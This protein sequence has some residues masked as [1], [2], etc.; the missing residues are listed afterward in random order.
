MQEFIRIC[1]ITFICKAPL[2]DSAI[3]NTLQIGGQ[4]MKSFLARFRRLFFAGTLALIITLVVSIFTGG[5][6]YLDLWTYGLNLKSFENVFCLFL[7]VSPI[8]YI[9]LAIIST[10]YIRKHGQ[11]AAY[12]QT[13]PF[14][15]T[16]F[17]CVAS[18]F[19]SPF[20]CISGFF[21]AVFNKYPSIYPEDLKKK[22]KAISI[23]RFIWMILI[24][25]FCV[26]GL[27]RINDFAALIQTFTK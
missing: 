27:I 25:A 3:H 12:Q 16:F 13:K 17:Q 23:G 26:Y 21:T 2:V 7:A 19:A 10:A 8:V 4:V 20:K 1:R 22:S 14:I 6:G 5:K 9:L 18:E 24:L 15:S 11:S